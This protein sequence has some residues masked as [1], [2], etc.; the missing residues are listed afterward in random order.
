MSLKVTEQEKRRV[1]NTARVF[2]IIF[3]VCAILAGVFVALIPRTKQI[4]TIGANEE[5]IESFID[6]HDGETY[7]LQSE[8]LLCEYDSFTGE[9]LGEFNL[10]AEI[11]KAVKI[12]AESLDCPMTELSFLYEPIETWEL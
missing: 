2:V 5:V 6:S 11:K 12:L 1:K 9:K 10:T 3:L 8:N 7:F 4:K